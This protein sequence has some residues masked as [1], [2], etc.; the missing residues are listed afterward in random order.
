MRKI[1]K[2]KKALAKPEKLTP[3]ISWQIK[4][5]IDLKQL[6]KTWLKLRISIVKIMTI[7]QT[8]ILIN[9]QKINVSLD[10]L[11]VNN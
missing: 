2:P 4:I 11:H 6:I 9:I 5:A 8:N 3:L 10:N 7:M 1:I